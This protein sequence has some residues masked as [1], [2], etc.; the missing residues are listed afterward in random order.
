MSAIL[1]PPHGD[2]NTTSFALLRR[3]RAEA[4]HE[5]LKHHRVIYLDGET[6]RKFADEGLNCE[7]LDCAASDLVASER[8]EF[9]LSGSTVLLVLRRA[10]ESEAA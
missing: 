4:L 10:A 1:P 3:L 6:Y 5:E 7:T 2:D 9:K 8:A